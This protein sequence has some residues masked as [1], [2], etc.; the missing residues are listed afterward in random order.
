MCDCDL[1]KK[2]GYTSP[3]HEQYMDAG[4]GPSHPRHQEWL[5]EMR[6]LKDENLKSE[7]TK[8]WRIK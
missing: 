3:Y 8:E 6:A 5:E 7:K 1:C 2:N 4:P